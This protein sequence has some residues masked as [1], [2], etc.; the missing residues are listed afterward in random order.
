ME[1]GHEAE[2]QESSAVALGRLGG[3]VRSGAKRGANRQNGRKGGLVKSRKKRIAARQRASSTPRS[4]QE[5]IAAMIA[6]I[7]ARFGNRV[8]GLGHQEIRFARHYRQ[9]DVADAHPA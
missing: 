9:R 8:I 3:L 7:R 2:T 1:R 4:P 5:I 6:S